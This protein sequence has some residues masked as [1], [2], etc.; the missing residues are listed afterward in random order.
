M[1]EIFGLSSLVCWW[2]NDD[3]V[4]YFYLHALSAG[5][6]GDPEDYQSNLNRRSSWSLF[7]YESKVMVVVS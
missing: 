1:T 7:T 2:K 4:T 3:V 5:T 6:D